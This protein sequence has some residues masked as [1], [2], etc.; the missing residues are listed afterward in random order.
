MNTATR[1]DS[2]AKISLLERPIVRNALVLAFA[3]IVVAV[4]EGA[5]RILHFSPFLLPGPSRIMKSLWHAI[6][7]DPTSPR[8]YYA[9]AAV[10]LQE[11]FMGFFIGA[12]LAVFWAGWISQFPTLEATIYPY[13]VGLQ[14]VPKIAL[15]PLFVIWFGFGIESKVAMATLITF[16][17]VMINSLVGLKSTSQPLQELAASLGAS[18]WQMFWKIKVPNALPFIFAGLDMGV[19]YALLGAIVGEFVAGQKGLGVLIEQLEWAVDIAGVFAVLIILS[20]IGII[21]HGIMRM[22]ERRLLFWTRAG[23]EV[24]GA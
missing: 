16:F 11:T 21:L 7:F 18:K 22:I 24:Y 10:T 5:V 12:S 1:V 20:A 15:A 2:G 4:W 3:V 23:V 19:V 13:F 9:H 8:S 6:T 14:S 17:P